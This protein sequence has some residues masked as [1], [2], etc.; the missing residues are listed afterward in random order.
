MDDHDG[1]EEWSIGVLSLNPRQVHCFLCCEQHPEN[2]ET[3]MVPSVLYMEII[4]RVGTFD[5][6]HRS[7]I[8]LH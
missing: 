5:I 4:E 7:A 6:R 2:I 3:D 1:E 8:K